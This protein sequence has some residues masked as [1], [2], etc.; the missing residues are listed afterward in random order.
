M[1]QIVPQQANY[2]NPEFRH[3]TV[4]SLTI[5]SI[6][7]SLPTQEAANDSQDHAPSRLL[8]LIEKISECG[9][10]S[11]CDRRSLEEFLSAQGY[12]TQDITGFMTKLVLRE[13]F[14]IVLWDFDVA[15]NSVPRDVGKSGSRLIKGV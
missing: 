10:S 15:G 9:K 3:A 11:N 7:R 1:N 2:S 4:S 5:T 8:R 13:R 6:R 12:C 14:A